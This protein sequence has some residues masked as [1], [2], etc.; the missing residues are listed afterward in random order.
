[1][2][3]KLA[4]YEFDIIQP[5]LRS[6]FESNKKVSS[7]YM[8]L[9]DTK[10]LYDNNQ[11]SILKR[12]TNILNEKSICPWKEEIEYRE[13]KFPRYL[14]QAMCT[15]KTCNYLHNSKGFLHTDVYRCMPVLR[16]QPVL[17]MLNQC[18]SE[19]YYK[20]IAETESVNVA[21]ICGVDWFLNPQ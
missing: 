10:Y 17:T 18:D 21:C 11:C 8:P 6:Y 3:L 2:K 4:N 19:G 15:C 13:D 9:I 16:S 14:S 12:T 20:W 1:M 7:S 5:K